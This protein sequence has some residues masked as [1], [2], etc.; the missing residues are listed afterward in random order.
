MASLFR[1]GKKKKKYSKNA[2]IKNMTPMEIFDIDNKDIQTTFD[3]DNVTL[4]PIQQEALNKRQSMKRISK[5]DKLSPNSK[6]K[7][8]QSTIKNFKQK[9]GKELTN[10]LTDINTEVDR[11]KT[12]LTNFENRL[13][14]LNGHS[15]IPESKEAEITRRLHALSVAKGGKSKRYNKK[16]SNKRRTIK[17]RKPATK[18]RR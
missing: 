2:D 8:K 4:S 14:A 17:K 13:H 1:F 5:Q 18:K 10:L 3:R 7:L 6:I 9:Y 15:A 16:G 12:T 11:E